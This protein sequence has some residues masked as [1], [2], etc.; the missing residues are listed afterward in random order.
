MPGIHHTLDR[1]AQFRDKI[2]K[3]SKITDVV[4][5]G[6]GA[7]IWGLR[8]LYRPVALSWTGAAAPPPLCIERRRGHIFRDTLPD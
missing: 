2:R 1:H 3:A 7:L 5:I 6:I 4:N 8:W